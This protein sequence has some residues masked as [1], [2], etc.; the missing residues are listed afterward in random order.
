MKVDKLSISF[1]PRLGDQVRDA[2][3]NAGTGV[4]SWLA[5]AATAKLRAEALAEFLDTWEKEHGPLTAE[6]LGRA[7]SQLGLADRKPAD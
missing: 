5:E 1:E 2:A 4:S 6:E 7:E 3:R